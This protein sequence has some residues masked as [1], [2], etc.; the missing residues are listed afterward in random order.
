MVP[1]RVTTIDLQEWAYFSGCCGR[2]SLP[3]RF[4]DPEIRVHYHTKETDAE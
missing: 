1:G 3:A 4:A 2:Q